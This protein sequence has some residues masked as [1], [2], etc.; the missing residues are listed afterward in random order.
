MRLGDRAR[1]GHFGRHARDAPDLVLGD[2]RAAREAPDAAV[3]DAHAEARGAARPHSAAAAEPAAATSATPAAAPAA[4]PAAEA[5]AEVVELAVAAGGV[6]AAVGVA[7]EADV[8]VA[9]PLGLGLEE[10][11]VGE[12]LELRLEHLALRRL[13]DEVAD[14]VAGRDGHAGQRDGLYEVSAF[15]V[16]SSRGGRLRSGLHVLSRPTAQSRCSRSSTTFTKT[17]RF[18]MCLSRSSWSSSSS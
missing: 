7:G 4:T 18:Q 3:D 9:A 10:R 6:H 16:L 15:H 1:L 13:R 12:S 5:A 17:K 2:D 14:E 11:D 8:G